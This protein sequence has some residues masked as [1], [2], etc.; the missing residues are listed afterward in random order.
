MGTSVRIIAPIVV[1][2][3]F[4]ECNGTKRLERIAGSP[5]LDKATVPL[6][7]NKMLW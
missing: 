6:Q 1:E 5:F 3:L 7:K 2:I 4:V